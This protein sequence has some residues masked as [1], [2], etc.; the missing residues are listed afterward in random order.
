SPPRCPHPA[1]ALAGWCPLSPAGGLGVPSLAPAGFPR[2]LGGLRSMGHP[3][4]V[5]RALPLHTGTSQSIPGRA[6]PNVGIGDPWC[7]GCDPI[8]AS[9][10]HRDPTDPRGVTG[11][12][13]LLVLQVPARALLEGDTVTLRC[14]SWQNKPVTW[15][16][17]YREE[18]QLQL[19]RDGTEL[20]LS[21]LRLHHSGRYRCRGWVYSEVSWGWI[22]LESAPVTV[23]VHG[24]HPTAATLTPR[25]PHTSACGLSPCHL[26]LAAQRQRGGPRSPP[27]ARRRPCGT[28]RHLPVHGHQPAGT[29]W[30][31]HVP[32][33]Q[34]RAGTDGD[35]AGTLGHRWAHS[36]S[37]GLQH[38]LSDK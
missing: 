12:P 10:C 23:T 14:R 38:L 15:V 26:H 36:G 2:A 34:P 7:A 21:P 24:E 1:L 22:K 27:G 19:F 18:K 13:S 11:P 29:G 20:S 25:H 35:T 3:P 31:P 17:F 33:V 6:E 9:R 37:L 28:F 30:A 16:S 4:G 32:G 5:T 8:G